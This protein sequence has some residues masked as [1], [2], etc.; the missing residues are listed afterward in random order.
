[1]HSS[2]LPLQSTYRTNC[3]YVPML[4]LAAWIYRLLTLL[5][6]SILRKIRSSSIIELDVQHEQERQGRP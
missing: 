6:S 1:M 2:L 3:C 5:S 4:R